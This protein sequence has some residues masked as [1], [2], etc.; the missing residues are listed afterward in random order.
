MKSINLFAASPET[1]SAAPH[2]ATLPTKRRLGKKLYI[3][4]AVVAIVIIA[5]AFFIPQ[6]GAT[7]PLNV[8]YV[9]GEK[10]VYDTTMTMT[11]QFRISL[12]IAVEYT[13]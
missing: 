1:S 4:I 8:D 11:I 5:V 3:A 10:M 7:I 2:P 12:R 6:G 9:V 13:K